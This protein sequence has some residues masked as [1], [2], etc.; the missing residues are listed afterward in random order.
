MKFKKAELLRKY[1]ELRGNYIDSYEPDLS[2][3][4]Y[5]VRYAKI[6][7]SCLSSD[8]C[9]HRILRHFE[10]KKGLFPRLYKKLPKGTE[11]SEYAEMYFDKEGKLHHS[12]HQISETVYYVTIP[13]SEQLLADFRVEIIT[14]RKP[15]ITL[16]FME[17]TEYDHHGNPVSI[18]S[19]QRNGSLADGVIISCEY[20]RYENGKLIHIDFFKEFDSDGKIE[21]PLVRRMVPDRI[22]NPEIFAYDF[23]RTEGGILCTRTIYWS[24]SKTYTG[25]FL[26]P[27]KEVKKMEEHGICFFS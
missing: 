9:S 20:Y 10:A 23:Q 14:G 5:T 17:W 22:M 27:E 13:I 21:E 2:Q 19:F 25:T 11:P 8:L 12:V 16:L 3:E 1:A 6:P 26:M 4:G 15:F 18:E 7:D 24:E